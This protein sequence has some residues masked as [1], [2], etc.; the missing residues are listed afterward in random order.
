MEEDLTEIFNQILS[1]ICS[2]YPDN[3]RQAFEILIK[4]FNNIINHPTE[5]RYRNFKKT[6]EIIKTKVL[7]IP[8]I[9]SLL[10]V[11]GYSAS[12]NPELLIFEGDSINSFKQCIISINK[13]EEILINFSCQCYQYSFSLSNMKASILTG[14]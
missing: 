12:D 8:E 2:K 14:S 10:E 4:L 7:I 6:N 11:L 5:Q 1:E 3:Y 9:L 13:I